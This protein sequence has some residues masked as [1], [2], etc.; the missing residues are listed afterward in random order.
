MAD[1]MTKG[2]APDQESA[3]FKKPQTDNTA[4]RKWLTTLSYLLR[5]PRHRFH[6]ERWGDHALHS[7]VS[8]LN[9]VYGLRIE[10]EWREVPTRF[11]KHCRVKVYWISEQSRMRALRLV[12]AQRGQGRRG[13][14]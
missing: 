12:A 4:S 8:T 1:K 11:E 7:T 10:R 5:G 9:R 14:M 2:A 3:P 6:A 13:A